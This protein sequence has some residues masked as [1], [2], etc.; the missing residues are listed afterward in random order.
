[1]STVVPATAPQSRE[2]VVGGRV[3]VCVC[4]CERS[5]REGIVVGWRRRGV[6]GVVE[7]LFIFL[8]FFNFFLILLF[9]T[10]ITTA[11]LFH[12]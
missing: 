9:H 4:V 12:T 1:M 7:G 3:G 11:L 8:Y 10:T 6:V 2:R 5:V